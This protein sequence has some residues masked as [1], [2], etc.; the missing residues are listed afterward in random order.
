MKQSP[1]AKAWYFILVFTFFCEIGMI[2]YELYQPEYY[3]KSLSSRYTPFLIWVFPP[4][5]I[6]SFLKAVKV[7]FD[8]PKED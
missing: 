3:Q 2:L 4:G 7:Y 1:Q 5:M 6:Y 8:D